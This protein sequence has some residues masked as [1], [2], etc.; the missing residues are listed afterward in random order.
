VSFPIFPRNF[1]LADLERVC[2]VDHPGEIAF[3]ETDWLAYRQANLL[4]AE[5]VQKECNSGDI[6]WVQG[7]SFLSP[8]NIASMYSQ[9]SLCTI[10]YHLMLV[11]LFLRD[12]LGRDPASMG[13]TG[14][15]DVTAMFEGLTLGPAASTG[16]KLS[17]Q[18]DVEPVP[19]GINGT[20]GKTFV[21]EV[22]IGFFLHTP[23]PSSEVFRYVSL[24]S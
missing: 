2:T 12:L 10:D 24:S 22:Q 4:F 17:Q 6:V 21:P 18:E 20:H 9:D 1:A 14:R 16:S 19:T 7:N 8:S 23:F 13:E 5:A 11:P 15:R 3:D